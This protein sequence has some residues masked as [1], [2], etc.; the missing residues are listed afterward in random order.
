MAAT[1]ASPFQWQ[2][3]IGPVLIG[4]AAAL[5]IGWWGLQ[6]EVIDPATQQPVSSWQ[7]LRA[8]QWNSRTLFASIG[9]LGCV[10]L[11]DL[12]YMYR[13]R[14]LSNGSMRWRQCFDSIVLW[15]LSS[16]LT[17]SVVGRSAAAV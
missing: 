7:L 8:F 16:A 3:W 14:I 11:R 15:E 10:L 6:Q 13:L 4:S 5:G 1:D 12:G 9:L 2:R 17:P